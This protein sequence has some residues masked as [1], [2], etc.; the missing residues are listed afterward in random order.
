MIVFL[1]PVE[2]SIDFL[3]LDIVCL[4]N[5]QMDVPC[6]MLRLRRQRETVSRRY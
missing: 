5:R 1:S 3:I 2:E 6:F 4:T